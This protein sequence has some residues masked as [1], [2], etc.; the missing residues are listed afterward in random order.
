MVVLD[1]KISLNFLGL[2]GDNQK[3]IKSHD[4][5]DVSISGP[6]QSLK[7]TIPKT[8]LNVTNHHFN[9]KVPLLLGSLQFIARVTC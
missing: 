5:P 6:T 1:M 3:K 8:N 7:I 2:K 4:S 9:D